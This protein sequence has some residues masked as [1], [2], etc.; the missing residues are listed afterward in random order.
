MTALKNKV[1]LITG[2]S[3]GIGLTTAMALTR[4]GA[5]VVLNARRRSPLAAAAEEIGKLGGEALKVQGD[6]GPFAAKR[7]VSIDARDANPVA[8]ARTVVW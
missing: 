2:S 8:A 4:G 6:A 5:K 3:Q 1:A 7:S